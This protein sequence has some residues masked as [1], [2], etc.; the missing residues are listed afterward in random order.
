LF[1]THFPLINL[2]T[3]SNLTL[4]RTNYFSYFGSFFIPFNHFIKGCS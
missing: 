3:S 4:K 1:E 2:P